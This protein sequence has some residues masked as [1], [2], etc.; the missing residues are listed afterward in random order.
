MTINTF[1]LQF[2]ELV[3]LLKKPLSEENSSDIRK[4]L[5]K[6]KNP[7][8]YSKYVS[9]H[10]ANCFGYYKNNTINPILIALDNMIAILKSVHTIEDKQILLQ[11]EYSWAF[12]NYNWYNNLIKKTA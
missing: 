1:D 10:P 5:L 11:K 3:S 2:F 7:T 9:K 6:L 4:I 12:N 8:Y